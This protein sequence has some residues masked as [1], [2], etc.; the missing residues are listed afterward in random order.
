M[1]KK[2]IAITLS[3]LVLVGGITGCSNKS[4]STSSDSTKT[5]QSADKPLKLDF[6]Q[7]S[8]H[9]D[10]ANKFS[11]VYDKK[12]EKSLAITNCM[13]EMMLSMGLQDKMAGT[14]YAENNI[15]PD[16]KPA[17]DKVPVMSKT[18][19]S[20][21]QILSNGVDF[22][23]GW[24]GD[25]NDKGV[26]SIDWLNENKIKAYI[27][28]SV[29]PDA[30]V[31]SIYEDF[32][33]LGMIFD[34]EDKAKELTEKMKSELKETTD[35]IKNVDKKVK[36]LGYDSGKDKAVVV[37]KGINNEIIKL[38]QGENVF[39]DMKKD[40]PEVSM[41]EIIKRN[42]DVIMVLEYSVG[43]GGDTFEN[44][45]KALKANPALKD[46]NAIKNNK[47]IKVELTEL[48]PGVRVPKTVNKLA[49]EFYPDKF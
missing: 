44:K 45:V 33:N 36:V 43:N 37:G 32:K 41:E 13:I 18:Y 16:L 9:D 35:K 28:R 48:Y 22:I 2:L 49:K 29:N 21:E 26:G 4:T 27:P 11:M 25:F 46:V 3:T 17:Y 24:G 5:E 23:I 10:S 15:L 30:T 20:K 12:P 14:A 38:A 47:F 39:G 42:P 31:D 34:K 7:T 40:Y 8:R 6:V 1:N 19:P